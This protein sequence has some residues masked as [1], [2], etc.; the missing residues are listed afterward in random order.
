MSKNRI[1]RRS[2]ETQ[3]RRDKFIA[4]YNATPLNHLPGAT[5]HSLYRRCKS[6]SEMEREAE[7]ILEIRRRWRED[8]L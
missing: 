1:F 6:Q 4:A 8:D 5:V 7:H 3:E 2:Q